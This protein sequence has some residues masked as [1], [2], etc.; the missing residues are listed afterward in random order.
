MEGKVQPIKGMELWADVIQTTTDMPECLS[1]TDLQQAS[2]Q[3]SH[4]Q[5][6]K[7]FIITGWFNSRDDVSEELKPY[8]AYRDE[9]A[10][11]SGI[12]LK[13]RHIIIPNSLKQQ[14]LNQ[15]HINHMGIEKMNY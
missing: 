15:L 11:I 10:V 14:V 2:S 8:W 9:L 13:G 12:V 7:H 5:K 1:I 4:I 3:D 6:L